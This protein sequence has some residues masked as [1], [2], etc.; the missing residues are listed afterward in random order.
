MARVGSAGQIVAPL[1]LRRKLFRFLCNRAGGFWRWREFTLPLALLYGAWAMGGGATALSLATLLAGAVALATLVRPR[2]SLGALNR[3]RGRTRAYRCR[4]CWP[5]VCLGLHWYR[6]L[7]GGAIL[8]PHL[9]SWHDAPTHVNLALAPLAEQHASSWDAMADAFR[10]FVGGASVEWRES[11]G[12]LRIVVG[13][14][15]LPDF[16]PWPGCPGPSTQL[17]LGRRHGGGDLVIDSRSTAHVL[18]AGATGS[19]KGG[20]IRTATAAALQA[21]WHVVVLDPKEAGEY[22]WLE[23]LGVP[24]I[25]ALPEQVEALEQLVR[26][27]QARQ[28]LVRACGV[29]SWHDLPG[30]ERV[31]FGPVLLVVDEAADLLAT[32]KGKSGED[33]MRAA[34]QHKAGELIA[35]LARKGRSAAIHLIVAIQR[36]ETA[37]LGDQGGAL[38][39]N[40]TARL[41]LGSLDAEGLRML[42]V[43]S[44]DPVALALDGTPGRAVCLGFAGDPRPSVCQVAWLEQTQ[45]R[46]EV[47]P[48]RPQ[49]LEHVGPTSADAEVAVQLA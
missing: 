2:F 34:L 20:A 1:S 45:A 49:G 3:C 37:Q 32:T 30:D 6:K 12:T 31:A 7:D 16:L 33:R 10:R 39:N 23:L 29:D 42:G 44:T 17:L 8:V 35:E 24:V 26:V 25:T 43:S 38:R 9:L 14:V 15:P 21:G 46:A 22:A 4:R 27:R 13:R 48:T 47:V 28:G 41:A 5:N 11:H 40:L 18:L 36:P 19:G